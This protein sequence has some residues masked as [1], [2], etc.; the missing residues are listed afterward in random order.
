MWG[1]DDE[2]TFT[3]AGVG[4]APMPAEAGR[5]ATAT[6]ADKVAR[7]GEIEFEAP[8]TYEYTITE[9]PGQAGGVTYDTAPYT[10]VIDVEQAADSNELVVHSLTYDGGESLTVT[11]EYEAE[12]SVRLSA[13]KTV[14][15]DAWPEGAE[16]D[17]ELVGAD[18]KVIDTKTATEDEPV[19]TFDEIEYKGFKKGSQAEY[20][21]TV[22]EKVPDAAVEQEDGSLMLDGITYSDEE[23]AVKVALADNGDG[24]LSAAVTADN[25]VVEAGDD[26][27][28]MVGEFE[29]AAFSRTA[30]VEL[31]KLLYGEDGAVAFRMTP[32]DATGAQAAVAQ[33]DGT[34]V[35][36]PTQFV[37][38]ETEVK[39]GETTKVESPAIKFYKR[40]TYQYIIEE[41]NAPE[42]WDEATIRA[43]IVV[44]DGEPEVSYEISKFDGADFEPVD[45]TVTLYNNE[46]VTLG[47]RSAAMRRFN[48]RHLVTAWQ[49]E[50]R[51]VL[52]NGALKAGE[53]TFELRDADGNLI[54]TAT[55]DENG[56]VRFD[57]IRYERTA[58]ANAKPEMV[59]QAD[60][61]ETYTYTVREVAGTESAIIYSDEAITFT[62]TVSEQDGD[63]VAESDF[64]GGE[65][66]EVPTITNRYDTV[67]VHAIKYSREDLE[68]G[69]KTPL[70]G[71]HYGLWMVNPD[72]ND[73]YIGTQTSGEDG[74]LLYDIPT[75][76]GVAY[77][78]KEEEPP[79]AGH[80]VDP[81]PTDYFTLDITDEGS[82]DLVYEYEF[83]SQEKFLEYVNS[84]NN[85]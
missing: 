58:A 55:N 71:A 45:G 78:F 48:N 21:Y 51:K 12:G 24:T 14:T 25:R 61:T 2:F 42:G 28:Y 35:Y 20:T 56:L 32:A 38:W 19:V 53:F 82:F 44:G 65:S 23:V 36:S 83:E 52:E 70:V 77:Y 4:D 64:E 13:T 84:K 17:F 85:G 18:G 50:I 79:P 68:R 22:R 63:L 62:V 60:G 74:G 69:I 30:T 67:K 26:A 34:Y 1:E 10:V 54:G 40:G 3:L 7:F 57:A 16:F 33:A 41:P 11:N 43:T 72:G 27:A 75:L 5:T 39:S 31:S 47:F 37:E 46:M 80:L 76:E 59:A 9:E 49:P 15:G 6:K 29:N 81:Y 73:V 8:G 66:V